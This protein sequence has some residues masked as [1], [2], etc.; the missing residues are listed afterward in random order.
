MTKI[1]KD[2]LIADRYAQALLELIK[3]GARDGALTHE[4]V[5]SDLE[6]V[7]STLKLSADLNEF[8]KNPITST[9]DKKEVIERVFGDDINPL[10]LNFLKIL[11]DKN[12]FSAFEEIVVS[13]G[14]LLDKI[15][16]ISRVKVTSAVDLSEDA[17]KKLKTKLESKLHKSVAFD[18]E[19]DPEIIAGLVVRIGDN[20]V[21]TSL[22]HRL[23]DL[24][25]N[26]TK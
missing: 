22:K 6:L 20:V 17:K 7:Q 16:N 4:K 26:I 15:N 10:I 18:W 14:L 24:S 13:H 19:T 5:S 8:L 25:K 11:V 12:R 1:Q 2:S 3:D 9:E 21:D 23:E